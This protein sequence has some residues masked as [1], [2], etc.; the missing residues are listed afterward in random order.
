MKWY[1]ITLIAALVVLGIALWYQLYAMIV[2]DAKSRGLK[3]PGF[4]G[5]FA[6]SADGGLIAYLIGRRS[7]ASTMDEQDRATMNRRKRNA[8]LLLV[9]LMALAL[10]LLAMLIFS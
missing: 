3:R 4:W 10:G 9:P 8:L 2:L 1:E 7:Y 6:T 5:V